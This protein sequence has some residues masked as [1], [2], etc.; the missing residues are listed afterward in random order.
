MMEYARMVNL[1]GGDIWHK[2]AELGKLQSESLK[3]VIFMDLANVNT[4]ME[5]NTKANTNMVLDLDSENILS[6]E[7]DITKA[8]GLKM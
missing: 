5:I 1:M 4:I 2:F 6:K 3:M 7:E 8:I